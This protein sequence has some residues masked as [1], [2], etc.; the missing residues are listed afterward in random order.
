MSN[1]TCLKRHVMIHTGE[2]PFKCQHCNESFRSAQ[3]LG[4]HAERHTS[5]GQFKCNKCNISFLRSTTLSRHM[6]DKHVD[7]DQT[8]N[9]SNSDKEFK[10]KS[11]LERHM[12]SHAGMDQ[13]NLDIAIATK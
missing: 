6:K 4:L 8:Y 1:L 7:L 11:S 12:R 5:P 10:Y 3:E 13:L 2:K 9:F